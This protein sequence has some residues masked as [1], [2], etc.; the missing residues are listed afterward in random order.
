[1]EARVPRERFKGAMP[2]EWRQHVA[3]HLLPPRFP[4][5]VSWACALIG[6]R[7]TCQENRVAMCKQ[8]APQH[9][10]SIAHLSAVGWACACMGLRRTFEDIDSRKTRLHGSARRSPCGHLNSLQ[11]EN[12][13]HGSAGGSPCGHLNSLELLMLCMRS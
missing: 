3:H 1:M 13:L 6:L 2:C 8:S 12:R 11:Q 9:L 10:L 4:L 5:V 7:G